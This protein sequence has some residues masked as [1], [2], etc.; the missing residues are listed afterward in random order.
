[1]G[2][3]GGC[4]LRWWI[5]QL[6]S[7]EQPGQVVAGVGGAGWCRGRGGGAGWSPGRA[8]LGGAGWGGAQVCDTGLCQGGAEPGAGGKGWS[9]GAGGAGWCRRGEGPGASDA[10]YWSEVERRPQREGVWRLNL[11]REVMY[12]RGKGEGES[13]TMQGVEVARRRRGGGGSH[14]NGTG[15]TIG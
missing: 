2:V 8:T 15:S 9:L 14:E 3:G 13:P 11:A 5:Q 12:W 7:W 1:M 4:F 10:G 6:R